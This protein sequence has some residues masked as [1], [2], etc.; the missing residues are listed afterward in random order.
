VGDA[1][2]IEKYKHA[3]ETIEWLEKEVARLK[4]LLENRDVMKNSFPHKKP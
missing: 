1:E 4:M 3:L 2:L